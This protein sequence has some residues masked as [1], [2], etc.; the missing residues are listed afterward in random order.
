M[1]EAIK[2]TLIILVCAAIGWMNV[3]EEKKIGRW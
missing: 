1:S 3:L 2:I